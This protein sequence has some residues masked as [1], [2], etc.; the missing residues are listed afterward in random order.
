MCR[1]DCFIDYISLPSLLSLLF[2]EVSLSRFYY[3]GQESQRDHMKGE[4]DH[5]EIT[6]GKKAHTGV[7][8]PVPIDLED[9]GG[10]HRY[11]LV[12][13]SRSLDEAE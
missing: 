8:L 2:G 5:K 7:N 1:N 10:D 13:P 6:R 4:K 9:T 3:K 11:V 12:T